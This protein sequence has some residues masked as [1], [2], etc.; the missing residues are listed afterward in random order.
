M[1]LPGIYVE[2]RGDYSHLE[3]QMKAARALVS[4][5]ATGISNA[6]NN[7]LSPQKIKGQIDAMVAHFGTL[8]RASSVAGQTFDSIGVDMG[9]LRKITGLTEQQLDSLQGKLL[10]TQAATAQENALRRIASAANLTEKE[11]KELGA[12]FGLSAAQIDKVTGASVRAGEAVH[13]VGKKGKQDFDLMGGGIAMAAG[14]FLLLEQAAYSVGRILDNVVFRFNSTIEVASLGISSAFLTNG[15]YVDQL[16][17]KVLDGQQA[18]NAAMDD[19]AHILERLK[20]SN[21]QTAATLEQLIKAYQETAPVA[22]SKGF[23][24]DQVER[25]TVAM[26]QAAGVVD[27][28]GM[29]LHQM[30]EET[31]S[32]MTGGINPKNTRIAVAL[33]ITNDDVA[34]YKNDADGLFAFLMDKLSAYKVAGEKLQS[35]WAGVASNTIDVLQQVAAQST[36]P[37]FIAIRDGLKG[38]TDSL[39][40]IDTKTGQL[41]WGDEYLAGVERAK[42]ILDDLISS[43]TANKEVVGAVFDFAGEAAFKSLE[44]IGAVYSLLSNVVTMA[45]LA[46][47]EISAMAN[48]NI[49]VPWDIPDMILTGAKVT[50]SSV[51]LMTD[52]LSG[53]R[54]KKGN[55]TSGTE[56]DYALDRLQQQIKALKEELAVSENSI[57]SV[58][59]G[60]RTPEEIKGDLAAIQAQYKDLQAELK[61]GGKAKADYTPNVKVTAEQE[62]ALQRR[63]DEIQK[64]YD[65]GRESLLKYI[66]TEREAVNERYSSAVKYAKTDE[67]I[68]KATAVRDAALSALEKREAK[69]TD[70]TKAFRSE[71]KRTN[72]EIAAIREYNGTIARES[73]NVIIEAEADIEAAMMSESQR[74][75]QA[76]RVRY[77]ALN[78][79]IDK[80]VEAGNHDKAWA[81]A[82]HATMAVRMIEDMDN[83][84]QA[85]ESTVSQM[86]EAFTGWANGMA[87]DLN[88]IMWSADASF[89]DILESFGKMVTQM[90]LQMQVIQPMM[91]GLFGTSG[92]WTNP[93]TGFSFGSIADSVVS[94]LSFADGGVMTKHGKLPLNAYAGGGVASSP[95]LA[96]FGEGSNPEAYV[97]LPDGKTIPV[98]MSGGG[99]VQVI[100][101]N[102]ATGTQATARESN[103]GQGNRVI[104]IMVEQIKGAIAGDIS[105]G[106]GAIPTALAST[107]GLNRT[108]G[109]Y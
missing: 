67:E 56:S 98:T 6:L 28:T 52:K 43:T 8:N 102:N 104:E 42:N 88:D 66:Q 87:S 11:I 108:A 83:L 14:K 105:R 73:A 69:A 49:P 82:A 47:Q 36:E 33:G 94:Y 107:Y 16:T 106:D 9:E 37:L 30:G 70:Q 1:N 85:S 51:G 32:L 26:V 24:K 75:T 29:L 100:I 71:L 35:T 90:I 59:F 76:I 68:A 79:L 15:Q 57:L 62:E 93:D 54:D 101:N 78:E 65:K 74:S 12:Q 86:S 97:P 25:F 2:I 55:L 60:N 27:T 77:D 80:Q 13:G 4:D 22:L 41:R 44:G 89:G 39:V 61:T 48:I 92:S 17:G 23:D 58:V 63:I 18:M 45:K 99:N 91:T 10:R 103:D 84:V 81:D 109:A 34:R 40:T 72:A 20:A 31:R 64:T 38:V 46:Q 53:K 19:S 7:A 5:Q 96:L 95:Q 50:S 21:L 3:K